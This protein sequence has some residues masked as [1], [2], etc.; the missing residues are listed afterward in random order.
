M[1]DKKLLVVPLKGKTR[2]P[3]LDV[4]E[5]SKSLSKLLRFITNE[6]GDQDNQKNTKA[7]QSNKLFVSKYHKE[8]CG[9]KPK[10]RNASTI[11]PV[12]SV[13]INIKLPI[14]YLQHTDMSAL[15]RKKPLFLDYNE[16]YNYADEH[17]LSIKT[18]FNNYNY[19]FIAR[20]SIINNLQTM[21]ID[22]IKKQMKYIKSLSMYDVYTLRG[23]SF[24][25]D[26]IA[27][28]TLRQTPKYD[29]G[30][31]A[32]HMKTLFP[33]YFQIEKMVD[34]GKSLNTLF[35]D[36]VLNTTIYFCG[37]AKNVHDGF[38]SKKTIK[39][40]IDFYGKKWISLKRSVR[41][42][43]FS[44]CWKYLKEDIKI[45]VVSVFI[46][47]LSRIIDAAPPLSQ[48]VTVFRGV[49]KDYYLKGLKNG[50]YQNVGFVSSSLDINTARE[51][52][53]LDGKCC[54]QRITVLQGTKAILLMPVSLI[55]DEKEILFNHGCFYYIHKPMIKKKFY[56]YPEDTDNDTCFD[57]DSL[58]ETKVSEIILS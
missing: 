18:G 47:D 30:K 23:Y 24:I 33:F 8:Y 27:N 37:E 40:L 57:N 5:H 2:T 44:H 43:I 14:Q 56:Q 41:F 13:N 38:A 34:D 20:K 3:Q 26:I 16:H 12:M 46:R 32:V 10:N 45:Q 29:G 42:Y 15:D 1:E 7:L 22:W 25:G 48:A 9:S 36:N 19:A 54:L 55:A 21:P 49:A 4:S 58:I 53:A 35:E 51:F 52:T 17:H 39:E 28:S 50:V 6:Q 11:E 31:E